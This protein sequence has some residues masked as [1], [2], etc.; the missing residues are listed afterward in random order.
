VAAQISDPGQQAYLDAGW[1]QMAQSREG[2]YEDSIGLLSMLIISG[3]W[4]RP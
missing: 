2:Y 1:T 3:N 4:W